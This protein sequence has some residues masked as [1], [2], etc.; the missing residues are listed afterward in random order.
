MN[1]LRKGLFTIVAFMPAIV[2]AFIVLIIT[3]IFVGVTLSATHSYTD[4]AVGTE[5][6]LITIL[7]AT[8]CTSTT[9]PLKSVLGIGIAQGNRGTIDFDPVSGLESTTPI[10][11]DY[12][13]NTDNIM[14]NNC[15]TKHS[16]YVFLDMETNVPEIK[17]F[18]VSYNGSEYFKFNNPGLLPKSIMYIALP[19]GT[20]AKVT[21]E[22][23]GY[24]SF[25]TPEDDGIVW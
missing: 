3:F 20:V 19:N 7:T 23:T 13:N 15:L 18:N 24:Y 12:N 17:F 8:E 2:V 5:N 21:L 9:L 25:Y 16:D 4:M 10:N 14:F 22:K 1:K 11:V 6:S